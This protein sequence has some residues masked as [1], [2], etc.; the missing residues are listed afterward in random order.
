MANFGN[1]RSEHA[2]ERALDLRDAG[3]PEEGLP[4]LKSAL[5]HDRANPRLWQVAGVLHR[6]CGESASAL[7]AFGEAARLTPGNPKAA[8]GLAQATLEAGRPASALFAQAAAL[9]PSDGAV[10]LGWAAA[11]AFRRM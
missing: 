2:I 7:S 4:L 8:H 9:A 3:R 10:Q 6:A 5:A 1:V 11:V